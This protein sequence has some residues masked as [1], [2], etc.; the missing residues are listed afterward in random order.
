MKTI[1]YWENSHNHICRLKVED[2]TDFDGKVVS[3]DL[4]IY[5]SYDNEPIALK[6]LPENWF[7][8]ATAIANSREI[9]KEMY[10]FE[11]DEE[12][13]RNKGFGWILG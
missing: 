5:T 6:V 13:V 11:I 8:V 4:I 9:M 1:S 12:Q 2:V 10:W 7:N 3:I